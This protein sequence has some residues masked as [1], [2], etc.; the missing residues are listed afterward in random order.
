MPDAHPVIS[1]VISPAGVPEVTPAWVAAHVHE[2]RILDVRDPAEFSDELGHIE[3]AELVPLATLATALHPDDPR[4]VV[5]VC[6]SG[7][8]SAKAVGILRKLG[9]RRVLSMQGGMTAWRE[10]KLPVKR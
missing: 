9:L 2:V 1:S 7:G 5:T 6:R 3:G 4:P 10:A 8:R